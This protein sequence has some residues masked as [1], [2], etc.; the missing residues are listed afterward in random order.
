MKMMF[1]I[2]KISIIVPKLC[3]EDQFRP[4]TFKTVNIVPQ[5]SGLGHN[6]PFVDAVL[7]VCT[8][9]MLKVLFTLAFFPF[10]KKQ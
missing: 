2:G 10:S 8:M 6:H 4:S 9:L 5:L 3:S 1:S 7:H